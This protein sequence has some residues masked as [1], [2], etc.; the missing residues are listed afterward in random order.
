LSGVTITAGQR[1]LP[2]LQLRPDCPALVARFIRFAIVGTLG[3]GVDAGLFAAFTGHGLGEFGARAASLAAAT[4]VTWHL[5][6]RFTFEAS[7][8]EG[9]AELARYALVALSAQG[10][11]YLTFVALR[12]AVP[13]LPAMAALFCGAGLA[14]LFSFTGQR[15][16]TFAPAP[17]S[18]R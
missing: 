7:G 9:A 18:A 10:L 15:L 1:P 14:A 11:N 6:R 17:V 3:L 4:L 8:R 5:N 2:T 12:S 16:F 13:A